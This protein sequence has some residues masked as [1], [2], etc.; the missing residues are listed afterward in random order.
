MPKRSAESTG[1]GEGMK[2]KRAALPANTRTESASSASVAKEMSLDDL[3]TL[4]SSEL[5][6]LLTR[7]QQE[8][9]YDEIKRYAEFLRACNISSD[10]AEKR[11]FF[12][13]WAT[14]FLLASN[15]IDQSTSDT[16]TVHDPPLGSGIRSIGHGSSAYSYKTAIDE[17]IVDADIKEK[18]S[19]C[20]GLMLA[21]PFYRSFLQHIHNDKN[22]G[23]NIHNEH[24]AWFDKAY[25]RIWQTTEYGIVASKNK[26][27]DSTYEATATSLLACIINQLIQRI[28]SK[29]ENKNL[30][31]Y[32]PSWPSE[33]MLPMKDAEG[34]RKEPR[35]DGLLV[36][37]DPLNY[38]A[39][40][41]LV[42]M[43]AKLNEFSVKDQYQSKSNAIDALAR[44]PEGKI[45]WPLLS[46]R[47]I[48]GKQA[49]SSVFA[50][51]PVE[52]SKAKLVSLFHADTV[53]VSFYD[54]LVAVIGAARDF[55]DLLNKPNIKEAPRVYPVHRNV[56]FDDGYVYK[57]YYQTTRSVNLDLVKEFVDSDAEEVSLGAH[58]SF[59]KMKDR[60]P[61]LPNSLTV[62]A[63]RFVEVAKQLRTLHREHGKVHGDIRLSNL[64]LGG[65]TGVIVDWDIAGSIGTKY[66]ASLTDIPDGNR[67][68]DVMKAIQQNSIRELDMKVE[69]DIASFR[70]VM[71]CFEGIADAAAGW[72]SLKESLVHFLEAN[73]LS[74]DEI[75][76]NNFDVSLK[77]CM[78]RHLNTATKKGAGS[79]KVCGKATGS[80]E[81][82]NT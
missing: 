40:R 72:D 51:V 59:L 45:P 60:G 37:P 9:K 65:E 48:L 58:G 76:A 55:V 81:Q 44:Q 26:Q 64:I 36:A 67:A 71:G 25:S 33:L 30:Q 32:M 75:A 49:S 73:E 3:K 13:D 61:V 6:T 56:A 79:A 39:L 52:E 12:F 15:S 19:D 17:K 41:P 53:K 42:S 22:N 38:D 29:E 20:K 2:E 16:R 68:F 82:G 57:S 23:K 21:H 10:E 31:S 4:E 78:R 7:L 43:E 54:V 1:A 18:F 34:K 46:M 27:T 62:R 74:R 5:Q 28:F 47:M 80:P 63:A 24:E 77:Q 50:V 11:K 35:S 14:K 66:S 69:H 70:A 8:Q